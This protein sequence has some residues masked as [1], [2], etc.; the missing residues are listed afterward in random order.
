MMRRRT[1]ANKK[2]GPMH[3]SMEVLHWDEPNTSSGAAAA[4]F[5][6]DDDDDDDDANTTT[7]ETLTNG[8]FLQIID[9]LDYIDGRVSRLQ[10]LVEG[11]V[12][13][14]EYAHEARDTGDDDR[15]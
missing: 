11:D 13:S 4:A 3:V 1:Q 5:D 7:S 2:S 6:D 10:R 9:R 14:V 8:L 15:V 12:D